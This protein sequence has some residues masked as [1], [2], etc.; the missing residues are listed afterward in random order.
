[1]TKVFKCSPLLVVG[2][3]SFS[4][5]DRTPRRLEVA[6]ELSQLVVVEHWEVCIALVKLMKTPNLKLCGLLE[7]MIGL[8]ETQSLCGLLTSEDIDNLG[9]DGL[10]VNF[11]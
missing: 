2:L 11:D 4:L 7:K 8:E 10:N 9:L 5:G 6:L 1:V 3:C